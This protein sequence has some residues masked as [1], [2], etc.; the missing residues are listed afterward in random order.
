MTDA[1][2]SIQ[3]NEHLLEGVKSNGRWL[4]SCQSWPAMAAQHKGDECFD[5]IVNE[6][7]LRVSASLALVE[8]K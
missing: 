5:S 6:F 8:F 4:F 7:M 2:I 3:I 1:V